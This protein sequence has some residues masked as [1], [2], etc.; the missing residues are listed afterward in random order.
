[1]KLALKAILCSGQFLLPEF[2][3]SEQSQRIASALART[4]W[5]S[6][7]DSELLRL[8]KGDK[9]SKLE[10]R[11]QIDRMIADDKSQRMI[12]SFCGQWLQLRAFDQVSPSLKLYPAYDDLL[13]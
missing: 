12:H 5:L 9:P 3:E 10:I 2:D 8:A 4:L 11:R 1:M 6:V 13:N 7:P